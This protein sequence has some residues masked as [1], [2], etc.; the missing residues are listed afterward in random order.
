[1]TLAD[2]LPAAVRKG[3]YAALGTVIALE[4]VWDVIPEGVEGRLLASLPA[5]G[6]ILAFSKTGDAV[7]VDNDADVDAPPVYVEDID[8]P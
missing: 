3:V 7:V 5:L 1:M 6:F 8:A 4:A 2:A